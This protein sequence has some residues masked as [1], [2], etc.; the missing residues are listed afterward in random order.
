MEKT[1]G[2]S[3]ACGLRT[4]LDY[5]DALKDFFERRTKM[6]TVYTYQNAYIRVNTVRMIIN[7]AEEKQMASILYLCRNQD[8]QALEIIAIE[9]YIEEEEANE[10]D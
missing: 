1:D 5:E 3:D 2:K 8:V 9:K 6:R 4:N 10:D 7:R